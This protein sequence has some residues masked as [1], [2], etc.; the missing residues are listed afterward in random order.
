[1]P[2]ELIVLLI[3]IAHSQRTVAFNVVAI[4]VGVM[5]M[6]L[7][8]FAACV[9][10]IKRSIG[11]QSR[12][13]HKSHWPCEPAKCISARACSSAR[14]VSNKYLTLKIYVLESSDYI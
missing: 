14:Y 4:T 7:L 9:K 6:H 1:M 5:R 8:C 12:R 11:L 3:P 2:P 10:R 13:R